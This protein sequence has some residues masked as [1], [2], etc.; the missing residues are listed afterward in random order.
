MDL[1]NY[2]INYSETLFKALKK[3]EKNNKGFLLVVDDENFL[4]GT[5]TDGDIRRGLIESMSINDSVKK[6]YNKNHK[7]IFISDSFSKIIKSFK[8]SRIKFLPIVNELNEIVNIITKSNLHVLLLEDIEFDM[9]Y[10]F[11]ELDDSFLEHEIYNRPW[12]IYKTTFI[13]DYSQSKIIK[14]NPKG[15]LSLQEHKKR[16][17]YWIVIN[18]TG[19]VTLGE[20]IK[21]IDSG[22]FIFIPKGCKHRLENISDDEFLMIAEV[23]IGEYFGEDD[24]IRY[25]DIYGRI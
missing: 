24:I 17:E 23:Q 15:K 6:I 22:D 18:G 2:T 5:L 25:S 10:N 8:D 7:K 11:L 1:S 19:E 13:N 14:V 21:K 20:S 3:I 12:G 4:K 16:E 9:N